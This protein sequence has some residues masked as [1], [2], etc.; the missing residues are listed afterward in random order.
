MG[1]MLGSWV[2]IATHGCIACR[3][4][5]KRHWRRGI[6]QPRK[7]L[8]ISPG[9]DART[10]PEG[11]ELVPLSRLFFLRELFFAII[12]CPVAISLLEFE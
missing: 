11:A 1:N 12:V 5:G 9:L 3:R 7:P 2:S 8:M 6:R 10:V 4:C